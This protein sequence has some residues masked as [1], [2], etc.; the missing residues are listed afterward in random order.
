MVLLEG[1]ND[2]SASKGQFGFSNFSDGRRYAEF[3]T[4]FEEG[5][6]GYEDLG[7]I[8]QNALYYHVG[9]QEP[10]PQDRSDYVRQLTIPAS[11]R[12][13]HSWVVCLSGLISTQAVTSQ[14]YHDRQGHLSIFHE[15][16]G[17]IITGANSKHQPELATFSEKLLGRIFYMPFSS[18]LS[19]ADVQDRLSLAYNTFF[20]DLLVSQAT[21]RELKF[22]FVITGKDEPPTDAQLTLQLCLKTGEV[23]E[24]ATGKRLVLNAERIELEPGEVG[25]WVRHHGWTLKTDSRARLIWPVFPHNPYTNSPE[26]RLDHA[27]G[28]LSI[29]LVLKQQLEQEIRPGEQRIELTLQVN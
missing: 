1:G 2:E 7:R 25:E 9:L 3:L 10:I 24:T 11:I 14:F 26:T 23:L 6:L 27:V 22:R 19:M 16:L 29:P 15:R 13:S 21:D 20:A 5:C 28:A 4:F 18:R 17:L 12:K 8:A